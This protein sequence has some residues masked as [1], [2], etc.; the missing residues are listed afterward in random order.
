M[1]SV[2]AESDLITSQVCYTPKSPFGRHEPYISKIPNCIGNVS[3]NLYH[4]HSTRWIYCSWSFCVGYF[5][6]NEY[7]YFSNIV[8]N[9]I[10]FCRLDDVRI[11]YRWKSNM[12]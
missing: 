10:M 12:Y 6:L 3:N 8:I 7:R 11:N 9:N 2:L 1:S 4:L 5:K